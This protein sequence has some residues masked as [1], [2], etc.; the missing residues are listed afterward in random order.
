M[1]VGGDYRRLAECSFARLH[2]AGPGLTK[3]DLPASRMSILTARSGSVRYWELT[4][5]AAG[6][7]RSD[8]TLT[9]VQTI[10]GP[11]TVG[12]RDVIP[13]VRECAAGAS[14]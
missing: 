9:S 12:P 11:D 6:E 4:F 13:V 2:V 7:N 1:A 10:W 3:A 5:R 14:S 8:V